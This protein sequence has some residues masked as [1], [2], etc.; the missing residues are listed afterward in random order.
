MGARKRGSN[1]EGGV[2]CVSE[3]ERHRDRDRDIDR[4]SRGRRRERGGG[5]ETKGGVGDGGRARETMRVQNHKDL[6]SHIDT[7][8]RHRHMQK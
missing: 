3:T 8:H 5:R 2:E 7:V 1:R 4:D 6:D